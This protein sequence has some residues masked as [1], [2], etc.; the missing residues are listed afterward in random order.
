MNHIVNSLFKTP[1]LKYFEDK[2]RYEKPLR[3]SEYIR[4]YV[5][6]R[7]GKLLPIVSILKQY[8]PIRLHERRCS[9]PWRWKRSYLTFLRLVD[10]EEFG[11]EF[12][13]WLIRRE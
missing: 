12:L 1:T 3:I 4:I 9:I 6:I 13:S 2:R 10:A 7:D 5:Y 8:V 11:G